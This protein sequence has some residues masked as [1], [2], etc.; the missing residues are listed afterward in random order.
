MM[1]KS[2]DAINRFRNETLR[3]FG[4][5]EIQLS[6]IYTGRQ[7]REYLVGQGKGKYSYADIKSWCWVKNWERAFTP[8]EMQA[9]PNLL[10]WIERI[11]NRAAVKRG[12]GEK[13]IKK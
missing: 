5:L 9:M 2:K 11:G 4:V 1:L 3:V 12:I 6:G 7:S 13:Y 10:A 8:E